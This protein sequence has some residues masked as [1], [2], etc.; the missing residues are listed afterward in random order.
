M[1]I[2]RELISRRLKVRHTKNFR[3]PKAIL[4][5]N[6]CTR[7]SFLGSVDAAVVYH[8]ASIRFTDGSEFGMGG[9]VGVS[10]QS[11]T[12]GDLWDWQP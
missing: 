1:A 10:T 8:N 3:A 2:R 9:E 6:N 4:T 7:R 12:P 5:D 11:S